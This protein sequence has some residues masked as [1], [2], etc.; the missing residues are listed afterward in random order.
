MPVIELDPNPQSTWEATEDYRAAWWAVY[1]H[2][3][4]PDIP[5]TPPPPDLWASFVL[6]DQVLPER[7]RIA[8]FTD[9]VA[10]AIAD[11]EGHLPLTKVYVTAD[12]ATDPNNPD[13]GGALPEGIPVIQTA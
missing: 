3:V 9:T 1:G 13:N 2:T 4:F 11:S 10:E 5:A 8:N 12:W 6:P 7:L